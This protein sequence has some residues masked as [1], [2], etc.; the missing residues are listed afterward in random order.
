MN[1]INYKC[2]FI[3]LVFLVF[4]S[5][6][7]TNEKSNIG[8]HLNTLELEEIQGIVDSIDA[9]VLESTSETDLDSAFKVFFNCYDEIYSSTAIVSDIFDLFIHTQ[10]AALFF[11]IWRLDW[12]MNIDSGSRELWL[13]L[14]L[15]DGSFWRCFSEESRKHSKSVSKSYDMVVKRDVRNGFLSISENLND[16]EDYSDMERGFIAILIITNTVNSF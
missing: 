8:I 1:N 14:N 11:D 9:I 12:V 10:E 3:G 13:S 2:V 6:C 16:I 7:R 15:S 5:S 4:E